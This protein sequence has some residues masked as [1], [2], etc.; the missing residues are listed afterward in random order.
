MPDKVP[1]G[2]TDEQSGD[3]ILRLLG[4]I[5]K[6]DSE[7]CSQASNDSSGYTNSVRGFKSDNVVFVSPNTYSISKSFHTKGSY[8]SQT[9][10]PLLQVHICSIPLLII[11]CRG[12]DK[13]LAI[14]LVCQTYVAILSIYPYKSKLKPGLYMDRF[15]DVLTPYQH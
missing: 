7:K 13:G 15:N 5:I 6:L 9:E 1:D 11:D 4:S 8:S 10:A 2:R 14:I 12:R 3:Y